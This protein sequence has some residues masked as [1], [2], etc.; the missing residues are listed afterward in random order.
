MIKFLKF[1]Y[2]LF[3]LA[4]ITAAFLIFREKTGVQKNQKE[5]INEKN[6]SVSASSGKEETD[7][8][9]GEKAGDK[10]EEIPENIFIKVPF[11]TQTP[12]ANWDERHEEACEEA[13]LIM[14]AYYIQNKKLNREIAEKEI[15]DLINFQLEK[16]GDYKDSDA[17][18]M[19][20]L[21]ADYYN[22]KNLKVIYDFEK[23]EIKK[24]LAKGKPIIVPAAG[25]KLGNPNF[26]YP[27][28]L[29]HALALVGYD[30]NTI[31]T[32]D[33]GT[34]KGE[35]YKYNIDILY[36][37]IHDFPGNIGEIEKGRKAMIIIE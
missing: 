22:I 17:A 8:R 2:I 1:R 4:L 14:V 26:T 28:P 16:Y 13:S 29:Y 7:G 18:G 6:E 23:A 5:T 31:I 3:F 10:K 32:N 30:G 21:A 12:Q 34:R 25:R 24:Q 9:S 15:Q 11:T 33:P 19:V 35:G 20:K 27:G 37:A 36:K